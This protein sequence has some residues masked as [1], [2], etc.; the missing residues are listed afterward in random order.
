[1]RALE[2]ENAA[3]QKQLWLLRQAGFPAR[4]GPSTK[5]GD[6]TF[7]R[8][9]A[10]Q[11]ANGVAFS[12][13]TLTT[14]EVHYPHS[15]MDWATGK[16]LISVGNELVPASECSFGTF[17]V[18]VVASRALKKHEKN[19]YPRRLA[20]PKGLNPGSCT[21]TPVL[22]ARLFERSSRRRKDKKS[23]FVISAELTDGR[24]HCQFDCALPPEISVRD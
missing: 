21:A 7:I 16:P 4:F 12:R 10:A 24:V 8:A 15:C 13:T 23:E 5:I 3:I 20:A 17:K 19:A 14:I 6:V 9:S 1:M 11:V 22:S 2:E 18:H